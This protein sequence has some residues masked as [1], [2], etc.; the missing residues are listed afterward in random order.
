MTLT[1]RK[2]RPQKIGGS[3]PS[4]AAGTPGRRTP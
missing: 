4:P 2:Q 1:Y 3:L